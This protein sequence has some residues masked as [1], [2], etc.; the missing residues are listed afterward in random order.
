MSSD[1]I[2][3]CNYEE[4]WPSKAQ[5]EIDRLKLLFNFPW[6]DKIKHFGSTAIVNIKAKPIIDIMI[7][8][9][10]LELAKRL[11]PILEKNGYGYWSENPKKDRMFFVKGIPDLGQKREYH[12]HIFKNDSYEYM[13]R[14]FFAEYLNNHPEVAINYENLKLK[15]ADQYR[16]DRSAYTL[17]KG[18]FVKD[19]N[20]KALSEKI[21]FTSLKQKDFE[22]L[23]KWINN[24]HVNKWWGDNRSW[25]INDIREKYL[26]YISNYKIVNGIYK[27]IHAY[28]IKVLGYPIGYIQYYNAY[29][30]TREHGVVVRDLPK[31]LAGVDLYIGEEEFVNKSLGSLIIEKFIGEMVF[32]N[33]N[34]CFVDPDKDNVQAIRSYQKAG[35]NII[36]TLDDVVWMVKQK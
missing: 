23:F 9:T 30:F 20:N 5:S 34:A 35:F 1:D 7:G 18:A 3:I 11:I 10:D 15:L 4:I 16:T 24:P 28:I 33:F 25:S 32:G 22:L 8:V 19:V 21:K 31:S 17:A 14:P 26:T 36:K 13:V 27:P 6:I 2:E 29:D 12:V